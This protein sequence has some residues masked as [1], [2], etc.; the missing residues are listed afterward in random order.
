MNWHFQL[1]AET[2][3]FNHSFFFSVSF[4]TT[5]VQQHQFTFILRSFFVCLDMKVPHRKWTKQKMPN[6]WCKWK[7][8]IVRA[9]NI[10]LTIYTIMKRF[11]TETETSHIHTADVVAVDV[12]SQ[13][14]TLLLLLC[15]TH[16]TRQFAVVYIL[17]SLNSHTTAADDFFIYR[18]SSFRLFVQICSHSNLCLAFEP[19]TRFHFTKISKMKWKKRFRIEKNWNQRNSCSSLAMSIYWLWYFARRMSVVSVIYVC[20]VTYFRAHVCVC[21]CV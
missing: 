16:S 18:N 2:V 12:F 11:Q 10:I 17:I 7:P 3:H 5:A 19:S 6:T 13:L 4:V 20:A 14:S 8:N 15:S 1:N 21:V 9:H